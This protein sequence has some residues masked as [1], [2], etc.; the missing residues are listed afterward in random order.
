MGWKTV[1]PSPPGKETNVIGERAQQLLQSDVTLSRGPLLSS[2]FGGRGQWAIIITPVYRVSAMPQALGF[3]F[4][5]VISFNHHNTL[6]RWELFSFC[7][8]GNN[9]RLIEEL[10]QSH[11]VLNW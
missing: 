10:L 3:M 6:A 2:C 5:T 7:R 4:H 11:T 1:G 9:L 8:R